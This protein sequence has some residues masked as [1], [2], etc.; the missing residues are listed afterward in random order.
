MNTQTVVEKSPFKSKKFIF[1]SVWN[2]LWLALIAY[3]IHVQLDPKVLSALVYTAG[4]V[5]M[6]YLG[7]QS[8][9]DA[10]VRN[11]FGTGQAVARIPSVSEQAGFGPD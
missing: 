6:L 9:V 10:F 8:A 5:Q 2:T 4:A 3:G 11:R 7:G 1:A